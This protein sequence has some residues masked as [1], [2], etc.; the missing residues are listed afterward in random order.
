LLAFDLQ[1]FRICA[2][3]VPL[4]QGVGSVTILIV[5]CLLSRFA[6]AGA[7]GFFFGGCQFVHL[8]LG[9]CA[10]GAGALF[11]PCF[12]IRHAV[13]DFAPNLYEGQGIA[14]STTPN[15]KSA[16]GGAENLC[17]G[18]FIDQFASALDDC[19]D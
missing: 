1:A 5:I 15:R 4:Q 13:T 12:Q 9:R 19:A 7:G 17:R 6:L 16:G 2:E 3:G 18:F 8:R 10:V 14:A 11:D